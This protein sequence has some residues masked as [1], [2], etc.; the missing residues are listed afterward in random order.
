M[1]GSRGNFY[2]Q[3]NRDRGKPNLQR[4]DNLC[5]SCMMYKD[6]SHAVICW[7]SG[8]MCVVGGGVWAHTHTPLEIF[9]FFKFKITDNMSQ[10]LLTQISITTPPPPPFQRGK[11]P[12]DACKV[13]KHTCVK[14]C[15]KLALQCMHAFF[16]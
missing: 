9:F 13:I 11:N 2:K 4:S 15:D 1:E 8:G 10:N 7:E 6:S 14:L 16:R 5:S 3:Q 12:D